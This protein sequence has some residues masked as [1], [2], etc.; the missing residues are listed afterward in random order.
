[1]RNWQLWNLAMPE[2]T[3]RL[4]V[5]DQTLQEINYFEIT[6]DNVVSRR[7]FSEQV[8]KVIDIRPHRRS[9]WTVHLYSPG[10]ANVHP[11][12]RKPKM[13]AMAT[14]LS[15]AEPP[16]NTWFPRAIWAHN[17]NGILIGSA[18]F[19]QMIAKCSYTLQWDAP[20]PIVLSHGGSGP[21]SNTWFLGPTKSSTQ[22]ASRSV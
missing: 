4:D 6:P 5:T 9:T 22:T 15:T 16:S 10:G 1:M 17:P 2:W 20:F 14:S 12:Y 21:P 7:Q 11:I 19:A 8:V 3:I 18:V 13:V